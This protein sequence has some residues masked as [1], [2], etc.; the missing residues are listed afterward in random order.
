VST[1][2]S[3]EPIAPEQPAEPTSRHRLLIT[4][5]VIG[6]LLVTASAL[7]NHTPASQEA[8][9]VLAAV[10]AHRGEHLAE[11]LLEMLGLA[12]TFAAA[13]AAVLRVRT[14]GAALATLGA[15]G[16]VLGMVGFT[17]VNAEGMVVNALAGMA[18]QSAAERA[19]AATTSSPAVYVAFP[20]IMLGELGLVAVLAAFRRAGLLPIWP[21]VVAFAALVVDFAGGSKWMLLASDLLVLVALGWLAIALLQQIPAK[22]R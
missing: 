4:A 15:V 8:A 3:T 17:M 6:P 7:F 1:V 11:V 22:V 16:S 18:D 14:R 10:R 19:V 12:I 5:L 13:A 9:D 21:A 20:L 2:K